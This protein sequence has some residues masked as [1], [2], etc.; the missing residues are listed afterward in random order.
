MGV[1]NSVSSAQEE[2]VE[3]ETRKNTQETNGIWTLDKTQPSSPLPDHSRLVFTDYGN[4]I[5]DGDVYDVK[6]NEDNEPYLK[7]RDGVDKYNIVPLKY[8]DYGDTKYILMFT[9]G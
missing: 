4:T 8:N 9:G 2:I 3:Y 1:N 7:M 6:Y 5:L